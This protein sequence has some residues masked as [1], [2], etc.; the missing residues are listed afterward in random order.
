MTIQEEDVIPS[1]HIKH[2]LAEISEETIIK[3]L[4]E[5]YNI[6]KVDK[7][8]CRQKISEKYGHEY[9]SCDI[10]FKSWSND[11]NAIEMMSVFK[12]G[13]QTRLNY[14]GDK[15]WQIKLFHSRYHIK[16]P[17]ESI[18]NVYMI[19]HGTYNEIKVFTS[20]KNKIPDIIRNQTEKYTDIDSG[21][22]YIDLVENKEYNCKMDMSSL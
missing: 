8:F 10:H 12:N 19:Y 21:W 18:H 9:Y 20:D 22:K 2:V 14:S 3:I 7:I 15:F 17:K 5:T 11:P 6:G 16:K 13:K 4:E 1:M